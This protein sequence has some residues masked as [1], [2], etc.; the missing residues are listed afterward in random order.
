MENNL[1]FKQYHKNVQVIPRKDIPAI[2]EVVINNIRFDLGLHQD[3]RRHD[4][5]AEFI[6][7]FGRFSLSWTCLKE[8][9]TLEK[10]QHPNKSLIL[11][12]KGSGTLIGDVTQIIN[13][14]DSIIVP[15]NC[16]HGF[17]ANNG[18]DLYALSIQFD[19][20]LYENINNPKVTFL[21]QNNHGL[22][23]LFST[24]K[25]RLSTH[26][27]TGFFKLLT[28][29][30][31]KNDPNKMKIFYNYL[32]YW[33]N[34]FQKILHLRQGVVNHS[35]LG[36]MYLEHFKE[37]FGHDEILKNEQE[38]VPENID[39]NIESYA[40][41]F[42]MKTLISNDLER[43]I[44]I[45]LVLETSAHAFH[46]LAAK[47]FKE[48]EGEKYFDIHQESDEKH[49]VMGINFLKNQTSGTYIDLLDFLNKCWDMLDA[50]LS[51]IDQIIRS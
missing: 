17:T 26:I 45:H 24:N 38:I 3:F 10:H 4:I 34:S 5:L 19:E 43:I 20:G 23:L 21:S 42:L 12:I 25:R 13:E 33:S 39:L 49:A 7:E 16:I 31:L 50:M 51:K 14:G 6:P 18:E 29:G 1:L 48:K 47:V 46:Q 35:Q 32:Y 40:S 2:N 44:M 11:V 27:N 8:T 37:E 30:T 28:D 9:Q 36:M 22:D 41:W 15:E